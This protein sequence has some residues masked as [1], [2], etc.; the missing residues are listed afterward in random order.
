MSKNAREA[1]LK[2]VKARYKA[3]RLFR[4]YEC[5]Y[6][7]RTASTVDH[8]PPVSVSYAYNP[9][10]PHVK[11]PACRKCNSFL[12]DRE[13]YTIAERCRFLRDRYEKYYQA[14]IDIPHWE[15]WEI[16]EM[17]DMMRTEIES[18]MRQKEAIEDLLFHLDQAERL[19]AAI[20][21]WDNGDVSRYELRYNGDS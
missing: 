9:E 13:L 18:A 15:S 12:G 10:V 21:Q 1:R 2:A 19:W 8:V 7:G 20:E 17:G 11:V 3:I 5:T 6:C 16:D 4:P 14:D